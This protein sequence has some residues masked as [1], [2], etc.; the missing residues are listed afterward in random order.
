MVFKKSTEVR[1]ILNSPWIFQEV[2][3]FFKKDSKTIRENEEAYNH[4][5]WDDFYAEIPKDGGNGPSLSHKNYNKS[6]SEFQNLLSQKAAD[7]KRR[8]TTINPSVI[9]KYLS[10]QAVVGNKAPN[11]TPKN[12]SKGLLFSKDWGANNAA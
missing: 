5:I 8:N 6:P 10:E 4:D 12:S 9:R 11:I 1:N 2:C 3:G 7:G